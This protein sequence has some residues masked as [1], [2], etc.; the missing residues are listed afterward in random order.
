MNAWR[1]FRVSRADEQ[2]WHRVERVPFRG[3]V[4]DVAV[5]AG[6]DD[7][8]LGEVRPCDDATQQ[9]VNL[10]ENEPRELRFSFV[11]SRV[12]EK[13][14]EERKV[15]LVRQPGEIPARVVG[16]NQRHIG[17]ARVSC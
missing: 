3:S 1:D 9:F 15:V 14:F 6:G 8:R 10:I 12:G 13:V 11:A 5:V 17:A 4:F 7:E 16:G 2:R